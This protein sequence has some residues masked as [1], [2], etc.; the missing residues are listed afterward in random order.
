MFG[1]KFIHSHRVES[2]HLQCRALIY[3]NNSRW[4]NLNLRLNPEVLSA[5][6]CQ[7]ESVLV[8]GKTLIFFVR[9]LLKKSFALHRVPLSSR[10]NE[11]Q[12]RE[13]ESVEKRKW[14]TKRADL[15]QM[16]T[17]HW[18]FVFSFSPPPVAMATVALSMCVSANV[19]VVG[20]VILLVTSVAQSWVPSCCWLPWEQTDTSSAP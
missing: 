18:C 17:C 6:V 14:E 12:P 15:P 7:Y 11:M 19:R 2:Q 10:S 4:T 8:C 9:N 13:T 5:S 3:C 1:W 16:F 20:D